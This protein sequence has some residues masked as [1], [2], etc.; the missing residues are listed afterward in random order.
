MLPSLP[1]SSFC[2]TKAIN[3]ARL[4]FALSLFTFVKD[5][6]ILHINSFILSHFFR[7]FS[8]L[9]HSVAIWYSTLSHAYNEDL[10]LFSESCSLFQLLLYMY[11]F[12]SRAMK[13]IAL[14]RGQLSSNKP[15]AQL[16]RVSAFPRI[17]L[18]EIASLNSAT[19]LQSQNRW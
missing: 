19:A 11:S 9:L 1:L 7:C 2:F 3:A 17:H 18:Q 4:N 13:D 6:G 8:I 14:L 15:K 12:A 10:N 16:R 5:L